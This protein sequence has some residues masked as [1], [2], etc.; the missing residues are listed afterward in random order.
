MDI[1]KAA[2]RDRRKP[3][4]QKPFN[5]DKLHFPPSENIYKYNILDSSL[6]IPDNYSDCV[7]SGG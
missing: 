2:W 5:T 1:F 3:L 4:L 7:E 6:I